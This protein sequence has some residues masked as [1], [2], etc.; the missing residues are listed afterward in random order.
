[1]PIKV[2]IVDDH[3]LIRDALD[4]LFA[5]TDDI[6]VVGQCADGS[7]VTAAVARLQ[8]DVVLMDLRM[9]GMDGLTAT[10]EVLA[11]HPAVRVIVLTGALTPSTAMEAR[12]I[13]A[14][15][16]L[17]KEDDPSRLPEHVR[18]VA[19]GGAA[20]SPVAAGVCENGWEAVENGT[21]G[22][23]PSSYRDESPSQFR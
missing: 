18:T 14:A 2:L 9:P 6:A 8:P 1:M 16:Y 13:G 22:D 19:A 15:G 5:D 12:A 11:A 17:L 7:E 20:W 4:D 21:S 3:K 23:V 10:A